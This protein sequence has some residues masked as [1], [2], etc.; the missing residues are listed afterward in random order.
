MKFVDLRKNDPKN[1]FNIYKMNQTLTNKKI[2]K[3]SASKKTVK[4]SQNIYI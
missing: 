1:L 4:E 2:R 3:K